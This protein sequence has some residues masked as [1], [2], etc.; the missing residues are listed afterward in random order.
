MIDTSSAMSAVAVIDP[1][2]RPAAEAVVPSGPGLDLPA[3]VRSLGGLDSLTRIAVATGP[4]SFTGLRTGLSYAAGLALG[5]GV[6]VSGLATLE[7]AAARAREPAV[8][9]SEA[10]RGRLYYRCPGGEDRLGVPA[11]LPRGVP[12]AGWLREATAA[13]LREA[14]VRLLADGE[15]RPFAEA[16]WE[17][18]GKAAEGGY[19]TLRPRYLQ[20]F[21][22]LAPGAGPPDRRHS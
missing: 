19:D 5:A 18:A 11:D 15:L 14:G 8:G 6:G 10:G 12:A 20:T 9:V 7:L 4:G 13:A 16:A 22:A 17:L 3:L 1:S 21:G 2:G